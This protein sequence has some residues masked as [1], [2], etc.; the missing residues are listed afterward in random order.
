MADQVALKDYLVADGTGRQRGVQVKLYDLG[1]GIYS[2]SPPS[3]ASGGKTA[4]TIADGDDAK[5]I[6]LNGANE[7]LCVN[8]GGVTVAASISIA[9][10]FFEI[11]TT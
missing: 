10:E 6:V 5:A 11:G 3:P 2:E 9:V 4:V 7:N 8:L 1:G